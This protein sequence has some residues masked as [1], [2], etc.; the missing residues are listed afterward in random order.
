MLIL[1]NAH[2]TVEIAVERGADIMSA[3]PA[4]STE[5][6]LATY[7]W[8]S[9]VPADAL[10]DYGSSEKN[11]LSG[12]RGGWQETAPNAGADCEVN[13][14]PLPFHGE[15]SVLPW[16][17]VEADDERCVLETDL[18]PT[19]R[20]R[21]TMTLLTD[22]PGLRVESTAVNTG[23]QDV[24]MIWGH[25]PAFAYDETTRLHLPPGRY[26]IDPG[27]A[28]G[29]IV[30]EG[31]WPFAAAEDGTEVD[32][33]RLGAEGDSRLVYRFGHDAAWAVV[34]QGGRLPH[35]A[36]AWDLEAYP[37]IW[38]W[39]NRA[40]PGFPWFGRMRCLA[41]EPQ[42]AWPVDGLA[43]AIERGRHLVVP[44]G[45]EATSWLVMSFPATVPSQVSGVSPDGVVTGE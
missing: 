10:T 31:D 45:G 15:S 38:I 35:V 17:V 23:V 40:H 42:R 33:S 44:V 4:G 5:N 41:V 8:S 36:M 1:T 29:M 37:S 2:L 11:W 43:N 20:L 13:G 25:H 32:L 39:Q 21:R 26:E 16:R 27:Q 14:L 22:R 6:A 3:I 12:Y 28:D 34:E 30:G 7:D 18:R 24:P 9:P 19:I